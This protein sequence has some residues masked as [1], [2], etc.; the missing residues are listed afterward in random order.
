LQ[1]EGFPFSSPHFPRRN[2]S[3][4][5]NRT[6]FDD[7]AKKP[8]DFVPDHGA[9]D[10]YVTRAI[11]RAVPRWTGERKIQPHLASG[12]AGERDRIAAHDCV[13]S[14]RNAVLA[15]AGTYRMPLNSPLL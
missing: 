1:P 6:L 4:G 14:T 13:P 10:R 11:D 12:K 15:K 8:V 2:A 7:L 9:S 3:V 5:A